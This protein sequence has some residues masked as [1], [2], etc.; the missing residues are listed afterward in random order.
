MAIIGDCLDLFDP[1]FATQVG[2][3]YHESV[4]VDIDVVQYDRMVDLSRFLDELFN[5][6]LFLLVLPVLHT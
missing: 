1:P 5:D 3:Y 4:I 6:G 2:K